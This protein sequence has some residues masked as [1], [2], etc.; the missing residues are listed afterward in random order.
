MN[1]IELLSVAFFGNK[2]RLAGARTSSIKQEI[3][4]VTHTHT[5]AVEMVSNNNQNC[6]VNQSKTFI[7]LFI[8]AQ[9]KRDNEIWLMKSWSRVYV[10]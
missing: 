8:E 3:L 1:G 2:I 5:S 7:R 10:N 6:V 4:E 9:F